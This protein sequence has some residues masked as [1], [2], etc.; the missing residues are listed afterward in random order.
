MLR[1]FAASRS[2]TVSASRTSYGGEMTVPRS[3]TTAGSN[4]S[5]RNGAS[6]NGRGA[7]SSEGEPSVT[8]RE[9]YESRGEP[10]PEGS[11]RALWDDYDVAMLDLDGVVYIGPDAVPGAPGHLAAARRSGMRLAYVTNNASRPPSRVATHLR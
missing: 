1:R 2:R 5:P 3:P 10:V 9:S 8:I 7:P 6:T 11:P 4:R